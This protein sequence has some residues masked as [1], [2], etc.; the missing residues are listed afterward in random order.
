[1]PHML[2]NLGPNR[3]RTNVVMPSTVRVP[4]EQSLSA[5]HSDA[6][7]WHLPGRRFRDP[8]EVGATVCWMC[9]PDCIFLTG[10]VFDLSRGLDLLPDQSRYEPPLTLSVSPT[11]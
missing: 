5:E 1:M 4:M 6:L 9:D 2:A 7:M 8:E 11:T 3:G 10:I